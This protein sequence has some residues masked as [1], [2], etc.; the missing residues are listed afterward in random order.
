MAFAI[1]GECFRIGLVGMNKNQALQMLSL[2]ALW[3]ASF[4]FLRIVAPV[5]G[6]FVTID[7]RVALAG[8]TIALFAF[9]TGKSLRSEYKWYKMLLLATINSA[10]PFT[11]I[12]YA[13]MHLTA[14]FGAILNATTSLFTAFWA[15]VICKARY[16]P[17]Q[18]FGFLLGISGVVVLV[19]FHPGKIDSALLLSCGAM[20]LGTLF[21]GIGGIYAAKAFEGMSPLSLAFGQQVASTIVLL[22]FAAITCPKVMPSHHV[23][24]ALLGLGVLSTALAYML[25]F[26]LIKGLGASKTLTVTYIIPVFGVFWG[27]LFLDEGVTS[28][29]YV[30][31]FIILLGVFCING[32]EKKRYQV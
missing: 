22:P 12:A 5:L 8:L 4:L 18:Y 10:I 21:Y 31:M 24:L 16:R 30:G 28:N 20:L 15:V 23:I 17:L 26:N 25:Y 29:L 11:L 9:F 32:I 27:W 2:G 6:P 19:G 14:G 13:E 3:G 1:N 7:C